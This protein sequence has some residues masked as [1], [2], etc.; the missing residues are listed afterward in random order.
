M[1][2]IPPA[3][4]YA[5]G[6][7]FMV[8]APGGG[9]F[10]YYPSGRMA[11]AYERMGGGFY[12]FAYADDSRGTTLMA[13]D[14]SGCGYAAF[15][16]GKPRLTSRKPGG[17]FVGEDGAILRSWSS[18]KPLRTTEPIA[19]DLSTNIHVTFASRQLVTARFSCQGMTEDF[20]LGEVQKMSTDSYLNKSLGVIKMGPERGKHIL[21][22]DLCRQ[23]AEAN[24]ERRGTAMKEMAKAKKSN[25]TEAD[26]RK[27]PQ[28][29]AVV[30]STA[31]L[32]ASVARGEWNVEVAIPKAGL[33]A[34]LASELPALK[35]GDSLRGD[36]FSRTLSSLPATQPDV[37]ADLLQ[38][39][40]FDGRPLPLSSSIRAASGRYRPEHGT[41]QKTTRRRLRLLSAKGFDSFVSSD[42]PQNKVVV[43]CCLA[44]WLPQ[45]RR[46]E[47]ALELLHG[48]VHAQAA[49]EGG[50]GAYDGEFLLCKFDMSES[51]YLRDRYNIQTLPMYLMYYGGKLAYASNTLNGYG[52]SAHDL[53][54]QVRETATAA[55]RGA[56]LPDNF[57]FGETDNNLTGQ[58]GSMLDK[59]STKLASSARF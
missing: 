35:Y 56:F 16:N 51:R 11:T 5:G 24:R 18:V 28:L 10:G 4:R 1:V 49:R 29:G 21:D 20:E 44:G 23:A 12:F 39:S 52:T 30:A 26:M 32:Q 50:G 41:H 25:I 17:T 46:V 36:P 15:P 48:E 6:S 43:V 38:S 57:R 42:A 58:F 45:C 59:T 31:E 2:E 14:P 40:T 9:S 27:H 37:L 47:P 3:K 8:Y 19:F 13:I 53:Q 55:Q 7:N 34:T 54:A 22:T 33:A